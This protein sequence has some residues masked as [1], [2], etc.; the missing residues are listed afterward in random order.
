[1]NYNSESNNPLNAKL[2]FAFEIGLKLLLASLL[3]SIVVVQI[4]VGVLFILWIILMM[5]GQRYKPTQLD[6]PILVFILVR[7]LTI[8][9]SEYLSLSIVS[10]SRELIFYVSYFF[11][12]YFLQTADRS[13]ISSLLRWL[14]ISTAIITPVAIMQFILGY[15]LRANGLSGGGTLATHLSMMIVL[16]LIA[17]N[18]KSLFPKPVYSYAAL[19]IFALGLL[20]SM[21]RGDTI[22]VFFAVMLY[23]F[24]F[25]R[26]LAIGVALF[27]FI[28]AISIPMIRVRFATLIDPVNNSS[29][30]IVLWQTA[31]ERAGEHPIMGFGPET[32]HV[33]FNNLAK[34]DDK[35]IGGWHND[36]IQMYMESGIIGIVSFGVIIVLLLS[37]ALRL[38]RYYK[39]KE[40][41]LNYGWLGLLLIIVYLIIGMFGTPT[42]SIT[43][44]ILFRFLV[45][46]IVVDYHRVYSSI[47]V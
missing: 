44:A 30:R 38:I 2:L 29:D 3:V 13:K 24:L 6:L 4:L 33:V 16:T 18:D 34:V 5:R 28:I 1:M 7:I 21:T 27:L 47:R 9:F 37:F 20:F 35:F 45:A 26:K 15:T 42:F 12:V 11:T 41:A 46:M 25:N 8:I 31:F 17:R 36:F 10:I 19:L 43:N 14:I 23:A 22:A 32:F 39:G 40:V